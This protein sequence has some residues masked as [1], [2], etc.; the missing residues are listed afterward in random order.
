MIIQKNHSLQPFNTFGLDAKAKLFAKVSTTEALSSFLKT[1]KSP[2]F[3]LGGGS[4]ILLSKDIN[5]LVLKNEIKGIE[6]IR[7]YKNC[8]HVAVGGG[9]NW[10]RFVLWAISKKLGGIENLSLIPGTVGAAP[11]QNIGA[12]GVELKD[13]FVK[14][15]AIHLAT[16]KKETFY[17]KDCHFGYRDSIFKRSLKGKVFISKV[18]FRLSKTPK[19]NTSYGDI[20]AVLKE[21]NITLPSIK[22]ISDAVIQIRSSKLPDPAVLGNAGSFFKNPEISAHIFKNLQLHF[23]KIV[24]YNLPD[25]KVKIPAGWLIEHCGW[26]GKKIGNTGSHAQQ[27][28]VIVNYGG[29]TGEEIKAHAERVIA[30]VK[31]TFGIKLKAEVNIV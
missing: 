18:V 27:A 10:H 28:L 4:N 25:G 3:I 29:A 30:S 5:A 15:E 11:I 14:L 22:H 13:V 31:D 24:Y 9:E 16:G 26:K 6:M 8:A 1:N 2:L 17:K 19:T 23:P 20:Q 21:R 7:D 12:Y